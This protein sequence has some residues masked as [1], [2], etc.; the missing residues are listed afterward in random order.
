MSSEFTAAPQALGYIYQIRYA[1]FQLLSEQE[2]AEIT[3]EKLE[4]ISLEV[5]G[6]PYE[7]LHLKQTQ[8]SSSLTNR[9]LEL[10]KTL[11]IWSRLLLEG[12]VKARVPPVGCTLCGRPFN[13][14]T[15]QRD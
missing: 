1:L 10:W 12:K 9:S 8:A 5:N 3:I 2:D 13:T 7:I 14:R 4:D 11:R 6:S 15:T